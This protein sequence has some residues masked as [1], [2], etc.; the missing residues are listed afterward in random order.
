MNLIFSVSVCVA[1][2]IVAVYKDF[3][4]YDRLKRP[5]I[6]IWCGSKEGEIHQISVA[7]L[8]RERVMQLPEAKE[9]PYSKP[10]DSIF[11]NSRIIV[12][13]SEEAE[14]V[15]GYPPLCVEKE[16]YVQIYDEKICNIFADWKTSKILLWPFTVPL[17]SVMFLF[18]GFTSN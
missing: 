5:P 4:V 12:P 1:C 6:K 16:V 10:L 14:N 9:T 15:M 3:C 11:F 8:V 17:K 18:E 13:W 2:V 7:G